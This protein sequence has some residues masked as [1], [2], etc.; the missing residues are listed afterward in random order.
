MP[1]VPRRAFVFCLL[2]PILYAPSAWA[3]AIL[4]DSAP[5]D[6][7]RVPAGPV[8]LKFRYNSRVDRA[9]SRL[10]LTG[11][12]KTRIIAPMDAEGPPEFLTATVTLTPGAW[13]VRWQVL[14]VDG[15]ITRGDVAFTV[16]GN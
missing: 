15:H 2:A 7:G 4:L 13:V 14:A 10:T 8:M 9:R 11:P 16:T 6:G 3:H 1:N 12:S 5:I